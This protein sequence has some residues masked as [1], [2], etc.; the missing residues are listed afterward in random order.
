MPYPRRSDSADSCHYNI[1]ALEF[2]RYQAQGAIATLTVDHPPAN[3]L[4]NQVL[5]EIRDALE[6][7]E[8]D[9]AVRCLVFTGAGDRF[10][11]AGADIKEFLQ[12]PDDR[13]GD[14]TA[15]GQQVTLQLERLPKVVIMAIN[16]FCFGGGC[17][18]AMAGD[19]RIAGDSAV[20]GQPEIKL[21]I[22]PG[23]GGTQRLPRLI[24][25]SRALE[26]LFSG[27]NIDAATAAQLGL[28]SRVVPA[29]D[30]MA[31]ARRTAEKLSTSAPLAVAAIKRAVADGLDR[32]IEE[33]LEVER[34]EFVKV[35]QTADAREGITAF[36]EKRQANFTG[37][38]GAPEEVSS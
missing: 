1:H 9:A 2:V 23:F 16:G 4:S 27:D 13:V 3:A 14:R 37:V 28:V 31:E 17:E 36:I 38:G 34:R 19:I 29:A 22:I 12:T 7:A 25:K 8:A 6:H 15:Q 32:P 10:F 18:L 30:L 35:R 26:L 20:F 33:A 11:I 24:G 5:E 21:G